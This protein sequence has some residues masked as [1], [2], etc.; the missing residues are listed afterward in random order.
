V[1]ENQNSASS[2]TE[3]VAVSPSEAA[4]H[5]SFRRIVIH[6]FT[7]AGE[8]EPISFH[9]REHSKHLASRRAA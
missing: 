6:D 7:E 8:P 4:A 2:P 5:L 9:Y 3:S 1:N